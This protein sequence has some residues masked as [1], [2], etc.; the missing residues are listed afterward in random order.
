ML[1]V[2]KAGLPKQGFYSILWLSFA[3]LGAWLSEFCRH[4][5]KAGEDREPRRKFGACCCPIFFRSHL[6]SKQGFTSL[7]GLPP[8]APLLKGVHHSGGGQFPFKAQ[9]EL[10]L[11]GALAE[12]GCQASV[13]PGRPRVSGALTRRPRQGA[14]R[15]RQGMPQGAGSCHWE[16]SRHLQK[17]RQFWIKRLISFHFK[18]TEAVCFL[19]RKHINGHIFC[20]TCT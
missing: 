14:P 4:F 17:F 20:F 9:I 7:K 6:G 5:R 19:Q 3:L 15:R 1:F 12:S 11:P 2:L 10:A 16:G 18:S 13:V 8:D